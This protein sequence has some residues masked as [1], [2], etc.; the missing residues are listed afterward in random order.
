MHEINIQ[1][2]YLMSRRHIIGIQLLTI[3]FSRDT[4][5]IITPFCPPNIEKGGRKAKK[6]PRIKINSGR[7]RDPV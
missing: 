7:I 3:D 5:K 2:R 1:K 4:E 6:S